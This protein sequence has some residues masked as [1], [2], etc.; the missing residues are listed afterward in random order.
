MAGYDLT[1]TR[2]NNVYHARTDTWAMPRPA[3]RSQSGLVYFVQGSITYHFPE[4]DWTAAAGDALV[5]PKGLCYCGKKETPMQEYYV[6]DFDAGPD[7][8][9]EALALPHGMKNVEE[10]GR[11]FRQCE[12]NWRRGSLQSTLQCRGNTYAILA[13]LIAVHHRDRRQSAQMER[14]LSYLREHYT[15]P[16]LDVE[17]LSRAFHISASQMR[18]L[19]HDALGIS[20]LQYILKLRMELAQN[21]LRHECLPVSEVAA[22]AGF[23]S[24]FYFSRLFKQRMG[25]PPSAFR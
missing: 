17:G 16:G 15:D 11:L 18:R 8:G 6:I 9:L 20:P 19:F 2:V 24:E 1:I 5:L 4:G 12:E 14:I 3:P 21:L 10:T 23:S 7:A 22:R 25:I 13:E